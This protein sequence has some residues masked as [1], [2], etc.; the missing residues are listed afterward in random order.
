MSRTSYASALTHLLEPQGFV[1]H[2]SEW[3][4]NRDDH[5]DSVHLQVSSYSGVTSNISTKDLA[6]ERILLEA[7]PPGSPQSMYAVTYRIG[8]LMDRTD[9]W[10]RRDPNGPREL[11]EAVRIHALPFFDRMHS[12]EGQVQEFGRDSYNHK[13]RGSTHIFY[14]AIALYRLGAR[15]EAC[16][17]MAEKIPRL[18]PAEWAAEIEGLRKRLGCDG[19]QPSP[20]V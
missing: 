1:R 9:H 12:L 17:M 18:M 16:Q 19:A 15:S 14:V 7:I 20:T 8:Y 5:L 3:L 6:S 2:G 13:W 4:R 11:T 10:W